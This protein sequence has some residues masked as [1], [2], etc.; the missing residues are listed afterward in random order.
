MECK[1]L[2]AKLLKVQTKLG[3]VIR[4]SDNPFYKSS[5]FDVNSL[6]EQLKP[7]INEAGLVVIQ[8]LSHFNGA[9]SIRTIVMDPDSGETL[10]SEYT[11]TPCNDA[12]KMG[13]SVTYWR[14][15]GLVSFFLVVGENDDDANQL[16]TPPKG[17]TPKPSAPKP[18]GYKP[19][20]W[21]K[22]EI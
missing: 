15:Y 3:G 22:G 18:G 17:Y 9:P 10:E 13:A 16:T 11:I 6:I 21:G 8:P 20:T 2:A 7:I 12:Q 14:R 5:Y 19:K 1:N 4:D